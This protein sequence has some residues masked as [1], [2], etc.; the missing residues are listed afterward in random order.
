LGIR[1]TRA[2][3]DSFSMLNYSSARRR[4]TRSP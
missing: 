1:A 2:S 4:I 3:L